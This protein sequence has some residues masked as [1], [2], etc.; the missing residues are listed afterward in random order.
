M[1]ELTKERAKEL[2]EEKQKDLRFLQ[3]MCRV[4]PEGAGEKIMELLARAEKAEAALAKQAP[5]IEAVG[6]SGEVVIDKAAGDIL[7]A[8]LKLR[9]EKGK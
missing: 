3:M 6:G 2:K 9:E 4:N 8:A 1:T 7:R 5:L